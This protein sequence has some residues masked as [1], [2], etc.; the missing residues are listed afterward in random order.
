MLSQLDKTMQNF[1]VDAIVV[2]TED[3]APSPVFRYLTR[4]PL[5]NGGVYLKVKGK[6]PIVLVSSNFEVP[7]FKKESVVKDVRGFVEV[8]KSDEPMSACIGRV[9]EELG[10]KLVAYDPM[11]VKLYLKLRELG[12]NISLPDENT[13]VVT[14]LRLTKDE[15]E[16]KHITHVGLLAQK[17]LKNVFEELSKCEIKNNKLCKGSKALTIKDAR[18]LIQ[19]ECAKECLENPA[20]IIFAQGPEGAEPHNHG[21]DSLPL[22]A[23]V[24]TVVDFFPYNNESGYWFDMTRTVVFGK[25]SQEVK[26]VYNLVLQ[27]QQAAEECMRE[28]TFWYG[29]FEKACDILE[30]KGF[31]T[32]RKDAKSLSGFIH[33]LGHGVGV[34]IHELPRLSKKENVKGKKLAS[35][36]VFSN[37]PGLYLPGKFGVRIEDILVCTKTG[38]KNLTPFSKELEI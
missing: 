20:G 29:P 23:N 22:L 4:A 3:G 5:A 16:L 35:G 13:D 10:A 1:N 34:Q 7:S 15:E 27:A 32:V 8:A 25:A 24:P 37:E 2:Y 11:P 38:V 14:E 12:Y 19:I 36:M 33:S 18:K 6:K 17:V 21:T 28:G 26:E 9:L 30:A 31:N